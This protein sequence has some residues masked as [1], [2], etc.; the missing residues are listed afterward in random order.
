M[1]DADREIVERL[2]C[3]PHY[4][5]D[6]GWYSCPKSTEG[7]CDESA[8]GY[9]CNVLI[10]YEAA[11][12]IETQAKRIEELEQSLDRITSGAASAIDDLANE[13]PPPNEYTPRFM[14]IAIS[15]RYSA[16]QAAAAK[17]ESE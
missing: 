5:C 14:G 16:A 8:V 13:M 1:N 15:L 17:G 6:D 7:C 4:E 11:D 10:I 9:N 12:H 3:V 2:R